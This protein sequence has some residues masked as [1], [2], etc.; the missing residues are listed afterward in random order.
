M[1]TVQR[2]SPYIERANPQKLTIWRD[3][4]TICTY[5]R[6]P[7]CAAAILGLLE[8]HHFF[9]L[10]GW[11][12]LSFEDIQHQLMDAFWL[13]TIKHHMRWLIDIGYVIC[14]HDPTKAYGQ[15]AYRLNID[16]IQAA[17]QS[18]A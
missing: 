12:V 9:N 11:I 2:R 18:I 1:T 13:S 16:I 3:Y 7:T 15:P 17:I 14:R 4:F 8:Q 5:A 10:D 6:T